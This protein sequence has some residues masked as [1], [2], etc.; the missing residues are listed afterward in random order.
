MVRCGCSQCTH[1]E[2]APPNLA[3]EEVKVMKKYIKPSAK[4]VGTGTILSNGV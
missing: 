2:L 3:K 4:K 1:A